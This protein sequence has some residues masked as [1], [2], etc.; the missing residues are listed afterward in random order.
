M[1]AS[2]REK[3]SGNESAP[4]LNLGPR[5]RPNLTNEDFPQLDMNSVLLPE[6][7]RDYRNVDAINDWPTGLGVYDDISTTRADTPLCDC[8]WSIAR[9]CV[10]HVSTT[11]AAPA[12]GCGDCVRMLL[13]ACA[14]MRASHFNHGR[15]SGD[16][17]RMLLPACAHTRTS[18]FNRQREPGAL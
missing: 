18:H 2:F 9:D 12:L 3:K 8:D 10:R 15:G 1:R 7:H 5:R 17:A 14:H 6:Q 13:R 16:Y 11:A 4:T